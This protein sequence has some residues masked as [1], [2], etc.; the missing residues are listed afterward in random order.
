VERG[1]VCGDHAI[2]DR[3]RQLIRD[4]LVI[5]QVIGL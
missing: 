5:G 1:F 2:A 4:V 3:W